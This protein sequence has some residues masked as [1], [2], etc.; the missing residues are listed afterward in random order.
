MN[1]YS[2]DLRNKFVGALRRG[3]TKS[4][5]ARTFSVSRSSVKSYA[6]LVEEG[7]PLAPKSAPAPN[8]RCLWQSHR[9]S[10]SWSGRRKAV[11]SGSA[12]K[13]RRLPLGSLGGPCVISSSTHRY[14]KPSGSTP[15]LGSPSDRMAPGCRSPSTRR[16]IL[17]DEPTF[18]SIT[19]TVDPC[20]LQEQTI[21]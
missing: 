5:A 1:A 13:S 6:K 12:D 9:R 7:R 20:D 18:A 8:S 10:T 14:P 3:M 21:R 2:E 17:G 16:G 11:A 15:C 4:E 19:L